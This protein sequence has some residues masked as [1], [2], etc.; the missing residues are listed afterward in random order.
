[1]KI[2]RKLNN[3]V[4]LGIDKNNREMIVFGKGIGFPK[5]P[6]ELTDLNLIDYTYYGIDKKYLGL[7]EDLSEEI[8]EVSSKI[9][10]IATKSLS[11]ALNPNLLFTLADHLNF[12]VERC[13]KNIDIQ[14][15]LA[16]DIEQL[17]PKEMQIGMKA[18]DYVKSC[19]GVDLPRH[20][21]ASVAIHVV[22]AE[23][24][25]N[26]MNETIKFTKILKEVT[27]IVAN[28]ISIVID[29]NSYNYS[30]F[31]MHLRYLIMRRENDSQISSENKHLYETMI[32]E[33]P[34]AYKCV[35]EVENYFKK[36]LHWDCD[37]EEL[38]YL[39]L[40]INRLCS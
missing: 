34:Q 18:L 2:I 28:T 22:N 4:A 21:A 15:P 29:E 30:R 9:V 20:E 33:Y 24:N 17:Y 36:Q 39:M 11:V 27:N 40:H 5:L 16:Y 8:F 26:D 37:E 38:L 19:L 31:V 1:M 25:S 14:N 23:A 7:I 3:N 32:V 13:N 12:A 6:Y 10:E 35:V